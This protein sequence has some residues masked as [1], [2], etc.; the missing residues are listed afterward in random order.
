MLYPRN[1][2]SIEKDYLKEGKAVP[3]MQ[4]SLKPYL[5]KPNTHHLI[6]M[7]IYT[8][9]LWSHVLFVS[10]MVFYTAH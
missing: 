9:P 4:P 1:L 8:I 10:E 7:V 2:K 6:E 3:R 5:E